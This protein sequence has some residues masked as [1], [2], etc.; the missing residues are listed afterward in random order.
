MSRGQVLS[1]GGVNV[2]EMQINQTIPVVMVMEKV[3]MR[4]KER[5]RIPTVKV[6]FC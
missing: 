4:K 3:R 1:P 2:K 6:N 5:Q